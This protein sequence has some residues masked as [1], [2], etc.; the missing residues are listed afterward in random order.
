[1]SQLWKSTDVRV[2]DDALAQYDDAVRASGKEW[3]LVAME[4]WYLE[5][6]PRNIGSRNPPHLSKDDFVKLVDWKLTRGQWRPKLLDFA[7]QQ[8]GAEVESYTKAMAGCTSGCMAPVKTA[9][10]KLVTLKGIGPATA[11]AIIAASC[12]HTPFMSDEAL[13]A[14]MGK[15]DYTA[16]VYMDF[17]EKMQRKAKELNSGRSQAG[18]DSSRISAGG[19][20]KDTAGQINWTAVLIERSIF[21]ATVLGLP[22][23]SDATASD[24]VPDGGGT[25]G[26]DVPF[27]ATSQ[28]AAKKRRN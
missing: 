16:K 21:A 20:A 23:G 11:S 17:A 27:P 22:K 28:G 25:E 12:P 13:T 24:G 2:W 8:D 26:D 4:K 1:M 15:R 19:G 3:K 14:V 18:A 7:K 6:L 10:D 9:I 5:E